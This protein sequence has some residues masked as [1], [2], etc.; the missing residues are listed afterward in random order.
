MAMNKETIEILKYANKMFIKIKKTS[1]MLNGNTDADDGVFGYIEECI[2][3]II[4]ICLSPVIGN[5]LTEDELNN[6][7]VEIMYA[8]KNEL[9]CIIQAVKDQ[10][11]KDLVKK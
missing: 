6:L 7:A 3:N 2:F 5:N 8:N 11:W 9:N 4:L 10:R 1:K